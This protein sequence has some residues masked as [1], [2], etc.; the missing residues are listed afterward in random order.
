[1]QGIKIFLLLWV[2]SIGLV[3]ALMKRGGVPFLL[4]GDYLIIKAS[5]RIYIP[6]GT[7]LIL[8]ILLFVILKFFG[9]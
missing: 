3:Y 6:L 2:V 7:S 1:M 8:T 4:P 9:I 5:R